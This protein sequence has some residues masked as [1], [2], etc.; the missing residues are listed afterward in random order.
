MTGRFRREPRT[1]ALLTS[2]LL[3]I[4]IF[5]GGFAIAWIFGHWDAVRLAWPMV[6]IISLV[7]GGGQLL[8]VVLNPVLSAFL[9]STAA[10]LALFPLSRWAS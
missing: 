2:L 10:L 8:V 4:P 5:A 1:T 9:A 7:Q 3:C 6:L